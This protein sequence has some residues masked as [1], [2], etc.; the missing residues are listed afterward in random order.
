MMLLTIRA[1]SERS[2]NPLCELVAMLDELVERLGDQLDVGALIPPHTETYYST[3]GEI[4]VT[5]ELEPT[6]ITAHPG[7]LALED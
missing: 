4:S 5:I 1:E 6:L 3:T 7:A 2:E